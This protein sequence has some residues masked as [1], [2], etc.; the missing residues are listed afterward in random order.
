MTLWN[1]SVDPR[2]LVDFVVRSDAPNK[3][4]G[5][6]LQ[7]DEYIVRLEERGVDCRL[8]PYRVSMVFRENAIVHIV[9]M[10]RPFD[11]LSSISAAA[12]HVI[13]VSPIH[14]DLKFVRRMR[15]AETG[16]APRATLGRLLPESA[17][18]LLAFG[19][20][21]LCAEIT[22]KGRVGTARAFCGAILDAPQ[23]WNKVGRALD[24]VA[25]VALLTRG[26]GSNIQRDTGW[27]GLNAILV[28]NGSPDF[29]RSSVKPVESSSR[30]LGILSVGRIEPRKRQVELAQAAIRQNV[31]IVFVGSIP[32]GGSRYSD[33]FIQ[34]VGES[35]GLLTYKGAVP[36]ADV[37]TL[38]S[39]ARVL[40]NASWVEVQSLVD[41]EAAFSGCSVV[42][43]GGG[44]SREFLPDHV[45]EVLGSPD[46]V[47]ARAVLV[48]NTIRVV[49]YPSS[50]WSW[51]DATNA[52]V[53]AYEEATVSPI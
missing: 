10:D 31:E 16:W 8:V 3:S 50:V 2:L 19:A 48:R 38:M 42:V 46:E 24:R 43:A 22:V 33:K 47:L 28:P 30:S 17:R 36:H 13:L 6:S 53:E 5:D 11:L 45:H 25:A 44:N 37:L 41:I 26:E 49:D 39:D 12:G 35:K 23:A 15:L 20:R 51:E 14:H 52:L 1:N 40:I 34:V 7:V 9:N 27:L 4:G 18:E 21:S 32:I 29:N